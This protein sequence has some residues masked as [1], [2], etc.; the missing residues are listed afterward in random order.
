MLT[1]DAIVDK[2]YEYEIRRTRQDA[3]MGPGATRRLMSHRLGTNT[4][5]DGPMA[6]WEN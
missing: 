3:K 6:A 1:A 5:M 4:T 2:S